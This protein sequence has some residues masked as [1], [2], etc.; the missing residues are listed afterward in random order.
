MAEAEV[1]QDQ[2]AQGQKGGSAPLDP[3]LVERTKEVMPLPLPDEE[4]DWGL[5]VLSKTKEKAKFFG[6]IKKKELSLEV[7]AELR[8]SS[9]LSPGNTLIEIQRL[10]KLHPNN[11][12]LLMLSATC[13]N[14]M[15]MNSS[16]KKGVLEGIK[17]ACKDAGGALL[18]DGITLFN[19]DSFFAIYYNYLSRLKREQISVLKQLATEHRLEV[20]KKKLLKNTAVVDYLLGEKPKAVAIMGHLKKKIKSSKFTT[21]WEF[22]EM[23]SAYKAIET[24][25]TKE[26]FGIGTA[27]ELVGYVYAMTVAFA[28]IPMLAPLVDTLLEMIPET[29]HSL[30]LRKR[31]IVGVKRINAAKI[32]QARGDRNA[33]G[34]HALTLFKDSQAVLSKIEGQAVKQPYES[35]PY[36]N[37]ALAAQLSMGAVHPEEQLKMLNLALKAMEQLIRFDMSKEHKFTE[38]AKNHTHSIA[39]MISRFGGEGDSGGGAPAGKKPQGPPPQEEDDF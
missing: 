38:V 33:L 27:N 25:Q 21:P 13:S 36:F 3:A 14:G 8:K 30:L 11:A 22:A 20:E 7:V 1:K 23:R 6:L 5:P 31:S 32:A 29:N 26:E 19:C 2:S 18:A 9:M 15:M 34:K 12:D 10:R 28:R 39:N 37:L 24:N 35:E 4:S 17:G 16:Q